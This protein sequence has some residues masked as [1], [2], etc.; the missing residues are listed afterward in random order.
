MYS[1]P[2]YTYTP[3]AALD[4]SSM[5][6]VLQGQRGWYDVRIE[7]TYGWVNASDV[8]PAS[9]SQARQQSVTTQEVLPTP[10][11]TPTQEFSKA[12]SI[13]NAA[14]DTILYVADGPLKIRS[15]PGKSF[16]QIGYVLV[17]TR[18][19]VHALQSGWTYATTP[20]GVTGWM[21]QQYLSQTAPTRYS[22]AASVSGAAIQATGMTVRVATSVLNV[23]M[24]PN[25]RARVITV[26]FPGET[27]Q[28]LAL[29]T[30]WDQ[31][32]L[33]DGT[34]GWASGTWLADQVRC[35]DEAAPC[36]RRD[37]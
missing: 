6:T 3:I 12:A 31:V 20:A 30:G 4:P 1:G 16:Q 34:T 36:S 23:R 33:R 15:G 17:G 10:D 27:V 28:V 21:A 35:G 24:Q 32:K 19:V 13:S 7:D 18:L 22:R 8:G 37:R 9:L 2:G 11:A 25:S 5:L 29:Q 26:L 14:G